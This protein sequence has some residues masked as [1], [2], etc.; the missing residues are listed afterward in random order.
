M[1]STSSEYKVRMKIKTGRDITWVIMMLNNII[2]VLQPFGYHPD[3]LQRNIWSHDTLPTKFCLCVD[4]FG[5]KYFSQNDLNHL[6]TALKSAFTISI[7]QAGKQYCGLN[8]RM[9]K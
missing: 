2:K 9:D 7:D 4:D 6:I 3:P 5:V 8:R 1:M